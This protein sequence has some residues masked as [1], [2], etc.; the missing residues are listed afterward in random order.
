MSSTL[1][2]AFILSKYAPDTAHF[3]EQLIKEISPLLGSYS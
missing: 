3:V 2:L 1:I